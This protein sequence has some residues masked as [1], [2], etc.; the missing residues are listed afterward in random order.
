MFD[1]YFSSSGVGPTESTE[2]PFS[3]FDSGRVHPNLFFQQGY[4]F[5]TW[6]TA[7]SISALGPLT[8]ERSTFPND[9]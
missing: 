5:T 7:R 8:L 2:R 9:A 6:A 3:C 4:A 1:R